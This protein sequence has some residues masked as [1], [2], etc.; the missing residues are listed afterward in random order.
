MNIPAG[1][2]SNPCIPNVSYTP[3]NLRIKDIAKIIPI[4]KLPIPA[5]VSFST[6]S[7]F[8]IE[9]N[10]P[11]WLLYKNPLINVTIY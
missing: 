6:I 2:I 5:S 10:T 8:L 3:I 4:I 9:S 7:T 11:Q 1:S